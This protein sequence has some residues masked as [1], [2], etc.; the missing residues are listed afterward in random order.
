MKK[1]FLYI[2]SYENNK[3]F[4]LDFI[5]NFDYR[6]Y[7][8]Y[9][10]KERLSKLNVELNTIDL[11]KNNLDENAILI[12]NNLPRNLNILKKYE[13]LKKFLVLSE[14][15]LIRSDNWNFKN[16]KHFEKIFTW[17]DDIVDNQKYFKI[18]YPNKIPQN[19]DFDL[20]QKTKFCTMIVGN[21]FAKNSPFKNLELYSERIKAIRWFEKNHSEKFDLFGFGWD[22]KVFK[23]RILRKM[24]KFDFIVKSKLFR[25]DYP[26]YKGIVK[27]KNNV[28]KQYKYA[29]CYENAKN[30]TGYISEKIFDCFFAGCVPV[31][32]GAKEIACHIPQNAFIDR[33][34]FQSYSELYEFLN[35]ISDE[36]YIEYLNAIK[37]FLKS[38]RLYQFSSDHF[39]DVVLK[40]IL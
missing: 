16:H 34:R 32:L 23:N 2:E 30:I 35:Q 37:R 17:N 27:S 14:S 20:K 13:K 39:V 7:H 12:F 3:I 9:L 24:N 29:I 8:Y 33:N 15:K 40:N 18:R 28:L 5:K 6:G 1:I 21:K 26:S 22:R 38:D 11:M 31:Y 4:D 19:Y 36:E 25:P 10:L